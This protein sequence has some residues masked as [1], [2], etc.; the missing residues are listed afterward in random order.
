MI[1]RI[2]ILAI[3]LIFACNH[4]NNLNM[5]KAIPISSGLAD[6]M[7]FSPNGEIMALACRPYRKETIGTIYETGTVYRHYKTTD[8]TKLYTIQLID[9]KKGK[10][11]KTFYGEKNLLFN[12]AG[13]LFFLDFCY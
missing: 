12:D 6:N 8:R 3:S 10:C 11:I 5:H 4:N 9:I 2:I 1:N 13:N 7:V